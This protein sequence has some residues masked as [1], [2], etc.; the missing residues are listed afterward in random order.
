MNKYIGATCY[1]YEATHRVS[2]KKYAVKIFKSTASPACFKNEIDALSTVYHPNVM[3]VHEILIGLNDEDIFNLRQG[4]PCN[5]EFG[6][7]PR[8]PKTTSSNRDRQNLS[9]NV[10]HARSRED[11]CFSNPVRNDANGRAVQ[12]SHTFIRTPGSDS[13]NESQERDASHDSDS[14]FSFTSASEVIQ[15]EP[16]EG[17]GSS[18]EIKS[19]SPTNKMLRVTRVSTEKKIKALVL[20]LASKGDVLSYLLKYGAFSEKMSRTVVKKLL[21]AIKACHDKG[22]VHRDLKPDNLLFTSDYNVVT[23]Y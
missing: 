17:N 15:N 11:L 19:T 8:S 22:L 13:P 6:T 10:Y 21:V 9:K 3:H 23:L 1:V 5:H 12:A 14:Y 20:P 2:L 16:N 7:P 4:S 18:S